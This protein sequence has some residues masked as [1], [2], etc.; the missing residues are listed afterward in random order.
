MA[1]FLIGL[2]IGAFV[3]FILAALLAMSRDSSSCAGS[4]HPW[5]SPKLEV[6]FWGGQSELIGSNKSRGGLGPPVIPADAPR[7]ILFGAKAGIR[8]F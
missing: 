7:R 2:F 3:G 8:I 4:Q 5:R 6:D 1:A